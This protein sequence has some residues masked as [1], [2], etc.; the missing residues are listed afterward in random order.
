MTDKQANQDDQPT[1]GALERDREWLRGEIAKLFTG[2]FE[3]S[4]RRRQNLFGEGFGIAVGL[5]VATEA[6][7]DELFYACRT[8]GPRAIGMRE[9]DGTVLFNSDSYIRYH[10]SSAESDQR[11]ANA[12][13][14]RKEACESLEA[15][16]KELRRHMV[17]AVG[18]VITA[19]STLTALTQCDTAVDSVR[20]GG[21]VDGQE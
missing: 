20:E 15:K 5:S 16:R 2:E 12:D 7:A 21:C 3:I 9:R 18:I 8:H 17:V 1:I 10:V 4:L 11:K 19:L 14:H 6:D 13:A